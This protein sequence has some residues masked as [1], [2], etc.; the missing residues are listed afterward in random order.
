MKAIYIHKGD[1]TIFG[2]VSKF[3]T[4]TIV[5]KYDLTG[6]KAQFILGSIQKDLEDIS[7]GQFDIILTNKDTGK[8]DY[9]RHYG[10]IKIIDTEEHI[11]TVCNTL[12]FIVTP[13][14]V[15]TQNELIELELTNSPEYQLTLQVGE[16]VVYSVNGQTGNVELNA[17]DV[18]ALPSDT[19][20]PSKLSELDNDKGFVDA[21]YVAQSLDGKQ[22]KGDYALKEEVAQGLDGKQDKGDY[23]LK[24]EIPDLTDYVKNTDYATADV[25]GVVK[26]STTYGFSVNSSTGIPFASTKGL[27]GYQNSDGNM[28]IGKATLENIKD[29]YVKRGITGNAIEL[30]DDEKT[31]AR[32]W[33]GAVGPENY[34]TDT[35]GGVVKISGNYFGLAFNSSKQL[36]VNKAIDTEV[37]A[38]ASHYKPIVPSNLDLAVKTGLTTNSLELTDD[39]KASAKQWLGYATQS[40]INTAITNLPQFKISIV[41]ALP[42]TGEKL[43]LYLVPKDGEAPDVYNE[44]LWI[45]DTS[46]FEFLGSTAVDLTDYVK[47]T[48]YIT[49]STAGVVRV[50]AYYGT[51]AFNGFLCCQTRTQEQYDA[52][53]NTT[54]IGKGTL[55]NI[56]N[57]IVK[58]AV[59]ENDIE[60]T[61]AEKTSARTWLGTVGT[62]D[63]ATAT[64][65]GI[66]TPSSYYATAMSGQYLYTQTKTLDQ[67]KE[68][69]N[70]IFVGKGTLE[71]IKDDYIKRGL[72]ENTIE[73]TDDEKSSARTLIGAVGDTDYASSSKAG[74]VKTN[75][76]T[77][78]SITNGLL[79]VV[80][81]TDDDVKGKT[82]VYKPIVPSNL[83]LAVKTG[84]TTNTIELT[85]DEKTSA[86]TWIGAVGS[87]DY[88]NKDSSGQAGIV[89]CS[90]TFACGCTNGYIQA[91]N[92]PTLERY[93]N[94]SQ[95]AFIGK[96]TLQTALTEYS[97]TVPITESDYEA[98]ETKDAN[99]LY[100]IE[101]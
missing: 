9:G 65:A 75:I 15:E 21:E 70:G 71:N 93:N 81:A 83:D 7:S 2:E 35:V 13:E 53:D 64:N 39:E 91:L 80:K 77:G 5:S 18:G 86:R 14:V 58:R 12:L 76:N 19:I 100:L 38:K 4:A 30:T 1:D 52:H 6:Y 36:Y 101:E 8:L 46:S 37:T 54:V 27:A 96:A 10:K 84:V 56:K 72:T 34:A 22:D 26:Q 67:Y 31:N 97:K 43:T 79:Y 59:T 29:D 99:T 63:Y 25:G 66:L 3:I 42:E 90:S 48:D 16:D 44:Y 49:G 60:L 88:A 23:A 94:L 95:Y 74:V 17:E 55:E 82:N 57:D 87:E 85:D 33:I 73:L 61:E 92:I 40:D 62:T 45:E 98:L 69:A 50:G 28:F 24:D 47:N 51:T 11:K 41:E 68:S 20:I 89:K 78:V 32:A